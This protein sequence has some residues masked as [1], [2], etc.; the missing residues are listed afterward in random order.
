MLKQSTDYRYSVWP[1]D[2]QSFKSSIHSFDVLGARFH[3]TFIVPVL[4]SWSSWR[5]N[6]A[7]RWWRSTVGRR[8]ADGEEVA[9]AAGPARPRKAP[10]SFSEEGGR[11]LDPANKE[12]GSFR[13]EGG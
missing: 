9:G 5:S 3:L 10:A 13:G 11:R 12:M 7:S 8:P 6:V 4:V 2:G 1:K